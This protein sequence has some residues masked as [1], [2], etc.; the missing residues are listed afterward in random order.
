MKKFIYALFI[1]FTLPILPQ[2]KEIISDDLEVIHLSKNSI[3]HISYMETESFGRF[4][5]N[6]L[7]YLNGNEA[8]VFDT[9]PD[10]IITKDLLTWFKKNYPDIK[11]KAVVATH[12]H[13]DCLGGL[14]VFHKEGIESWS[15]ELTPELLNGKKPLPQ[16]I[17]SDEA[18]IKVGDKEVIC[19][20]FGEAHTK[21]NIVCWVPEEKILFG[22]CMVKSLNASKGNLED[23][24]V[25]EWANTVRKVMDEYQSARIVVPGH[26]AIG[27]SELLDYTIQLFSNK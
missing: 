7:I 16:N 4:T 25:N 1:L 3:L 5:C 27:G 13:D 8:I 10:S 23:A 12:F 18:K 15:H 22:G 14:N 6:G 19:R 17:F 9:P 20:Y 11:I 2:E 21:D 24:N 26:G